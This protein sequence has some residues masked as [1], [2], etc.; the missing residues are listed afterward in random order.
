M[1]TSKAARNHAEAGAVLASNLPDTAELLKRALQR[2]RHGRSNGTL[3]TAVADDVASS[4]C[5][6]DEVRYQHEPNLAK[7]TFHQVSSTTNKILALLQQHAL[8]VCVP[9]WDAEHWVATEHAAPFVH[10]LADNRYIVV[11]PWVQA[12]GSVHQNFWQVAAR[13]VTSAVAAQPGACIQGRCYLVTGFAYTGIKGLQ[14]MRDHCAALPPCLRTQLLHM[15]M[16]VGCVVANGTSATALEDMV[17][18]LP[19][20]HGAGG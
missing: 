18:A 8:A 12:D 15:L 11:A 4:G 13:R 6:P 10:V 9:G 16:S 2:M 14:L 7:T 5:P 20:Q 17:F 19:A 3:A 1:Q